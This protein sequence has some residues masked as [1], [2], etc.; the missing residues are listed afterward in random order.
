MCGLLGSDRLL[1]RLLSCNLYSEILCHLEPGD[2]VLDVAC[3]T[4]NMSSEPTKKL[5]VVNLIERALP[6]SLKDKMWW[7]I[8]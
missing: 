1:S 7:L 4:G 3:G 2:A 6:S 5:L 8:F